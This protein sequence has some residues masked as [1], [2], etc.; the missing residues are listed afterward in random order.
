MVTRYLLSFLSCIIFSQGIAQSANPDF[1]PRALHAAIQNLDSV[2]GI[3]FLYP[4]DYQMHGEGFGKPGQNALPYVVQQAYRKYRNIAIP[5]PFQQNSSPR[6]PPNLPD[7]KWGVFTEN[8]KTIGAVYN[9]KDNQLNGDYLAQ[10]SGA[11]LRFYITPFFEDS[12]FVKD[13]GM[14]TIRGQFIDGRKSG[15]WNLKSSKGEILFHWGYDSVGNFQA[16][17]TLF[18]NKFKPGLIRYQFVSQDY[19]KI[20]QGNAKKIYRTYKVN[21]RGPLLNKGEY[22]EFY[23]NESLAVKGF[24][25]KGLKN[26]VWKYWSRDNELL[27]SEKWELGN[28]ISSNRK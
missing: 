16:V 9:V 24:Y 7:G 15:F 27:Y 11:V 13:F 21:Q 6:Y 5:E 20:V 19:K 22:L 18:L 26:G 14:Y 1:V 12:T 10:F 28:L 2:D 17:D 3:P 25:Q 8:G 23:N 4:W